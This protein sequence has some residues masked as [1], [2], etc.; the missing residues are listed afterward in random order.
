MSFL[1]R[2]ESFGDRVINGAFARLRHAALKP[3]D[4]TS[5][6]RRQMDDH[7]QDYSSQRSI[8]P[9][10][11][12]VRLAASD[13]RQLQQWGLDI[14]AQESED[15]ARRHAEE[16][17]YTLVGPITVNFEEGS[18]E[19][20]GTIHIDVATHRGAVAPVT[21][22]VASESVPIIDV[23]GERWLLTQPVTVVG[24]GE[25]AD[26]TVSDSGVSRRHL[27]LRK[28]TH[29]VIASDLGSTN[30]LYVEGHKVDAATLVDGN[31]I[32]IGRTRILFWTS[33]AE[34]EG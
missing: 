24:R 20:T 19:L 7:V 33:A 13:M 22:Q 28:T 32:V 27:E 2:V 15:E 8:A 3:V 9:N 14:V 23:E 10:Q 18:E 29:G 21:S 5:A 17:G 34:E 4:I 1:N 25:D 16:N 12:T 30:G 31:Q 26:I 11:F 6:V